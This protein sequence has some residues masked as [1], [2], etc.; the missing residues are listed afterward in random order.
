MAA[1][2]VLRIDQQR[3]GNVW[4]VS[5]DGRIDGST[6]G[7][8]EQAVGALNLSG[9]SAENGT[10]GMLVDLES[11]SALSSAGLRSFLMIAKR[12]RRE[13]IKFAVCSAGGVA[14][15]VLVV[16]GFH[17]IIQMHPTRSIALAQLQK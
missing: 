3:V 7:A 8:L 12:L 2:H 14:Q 4:V 13:R 9:E 1:S 10:K 15:Q 16:S 17:Q 5:A 11:V 6:A